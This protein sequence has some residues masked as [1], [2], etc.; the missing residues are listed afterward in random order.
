MLRV[1]P[2]AE[3]RRPI[4]ATPTTAIRTFCSKALFR[5][6]REDAAADYP[7]KHGGKK[8]PK[9]W[10][11]ASWCSLSPQHHQLYRGRH[12]K[13]CAN[14]FRQLNDI[15]RNP[16]R[17]ISGQPGS[18]LEMGIG[19]WL[20]LRGSKVEGSDVGRAFNISDY[21]SFGGSPHSHLPVCQL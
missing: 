14:I 11:V 18:I 21:L 16:S 5:L 7:C 9:L 2:S 12:V 19:E 1:L 10:P 6:P 3:W 15:D 17:V 13:S 8:Q 20:V 4:T